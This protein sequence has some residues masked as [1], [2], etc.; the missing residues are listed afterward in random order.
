MFNDDDLAATGCIDRACQLFTMRADD[1]PYGDKSIGVFAVDMLCEECE[2]SQRAH[3][4]HGLISKLTQSESI[5][6]FRLNSAFMLSFQY[7]LDE[8]KV[9]IYLSHWLTPYARDTGQFERMHVASMCLDSAWDC[10]DCFAYEAMREYYKYP[11]SK[12]SVRYYLLDAPDA[13]SY[14]SPI[15]YSKAEIDDAVDAY[16]QQYVNEYG[17]DYIEETDKEIDVE[18]EFNLEDLEWELQQVENEAESS[19]DRDENRAE[20][21][22]ASSVDIEL[23]AIPKSVLTDPIALLE[24]IEGGKGILK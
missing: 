8:D 23:D 19:L 15:Y 20:Q 16:M 5:V 12:H 24:W 13:R 10:F 2:R 6:F 4:V 18:D 9:S 21:T 7:A 3:D 22:N 14:D 11:L 17:D 1:Y